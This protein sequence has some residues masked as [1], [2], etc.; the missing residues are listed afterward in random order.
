MWLVDVGKTRP[1]QLR[2]VVDL[3]NDVAWTEFQKRYDPLL[4]CCCAQLPLDDW[5]TEEVCQETWIEV[6]KRMATFVYDPGRS[7][8]GCLWRVCQRKGIDYLRGHAA[9]VVLPYEER[10]EESLR[11]IVRAGSNLARG[12]VL[13]PAEDEDIAPDLSALLRSAEQIQDRV[14]QSVKP[15]SWDAFWLVAIMFWSLKETAAHLNM[16]CAAV[17]A[18]K[19][20]VERKLKEEGHKLTESHSVS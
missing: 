8:R 11:R 3:K 10:D 14:R 5:A 6:A 7:F 9:D 19:N 4:R 1:S 12:G 16:Q 2:R 13:E 18:A 20:R 15:E 17:S